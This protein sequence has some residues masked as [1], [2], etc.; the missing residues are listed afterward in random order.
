MVQIQNENTSEDLVSIIMPS[1]NCE[2]FIGFTLDSVIKQ[3]YQNWEV[4]IVDDCSTDNTVEVVNSYIL[5][6][7]RIKCYK[8]DRNS[9]A[10]LARNKAIEFANGK[11]LAF[12]DSDDLWFPEKLSVQ[13][14]FM[15]KNNY[16]FTCTSYT[17]VDEHGRYLNRTIKARKKSNYN[18]ILK[19]NPGN[20]TVIYNASDLGKCMIPNIK[21]RN[22]YVMWLQI[23]KKAKNLYGIDKPLGS[24]RIRKGSL[25]RNKMSLVGY[26][27]K[28]Y[29]EIE[30]L[31]IIRSSYLVFYW[32]I[33]TVFKLR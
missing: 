11:Y 26:H 5:K 19:R 6:D 18:D 14:S 22:D 3:T 25:S 21:K 12:L 8:L 2:D 1:Y 28:V 32:I 15:K 4:I 33:F 9:G 30:K 27:W 24:H 23:V 7:S 10:A 29:R 31:S 16:S 13:I 20:S 17:K